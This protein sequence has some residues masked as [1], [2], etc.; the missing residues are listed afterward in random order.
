MISWQAVPAVKLAVVYG[1]GIAAAKFV[2]SDAVRPIL[3][4]ITLVAALLLVL[5]SSLERLR[6]LRGSGTLLLVIA[7]GLL[8][9]VL[10]QPAAEDFTDAAPYHLV[11]FTST[12]KPGLTT[13]SVEGIA[14]P[15]SIAGGVGEAGVPVRISLVQAAVPTGSG[16]GTLLLT[17]AE[18]KLAKRPLNPHTF[19]F[20]AYLAQRGIR[21][22]MYIKADE[23]SLIA[24][25]S[26]PGTLQSLRAWIAHRLSLAFP[27]PRESG[28]AKALV[29][30]DRSGLDQE[31]RE[32][33]TKTGA[34]HVLA[35]SG[36][37]TGVIASILIWLLARLPLREWPWLQVL[38]LAAGLYAYVALTGFSPS[39]QRSA[40][41]FG[42]LFAGRLLRLD[43]NAFNSLGASAILLLLFDPQL[44]W[45]LGFQLSYAAV[46]GILAFYPLF[47]RWF[48]STITP[49][50]KVGELLAVSLAATLATAPITAYHF[51]QF[52]VYFLLSGIVAVPLV[53]LAL[54]LALGG[55]AIDVVASLL[56]TSAYWAYAPAYL[57]VFLCNAVLDL[58]AD[59]PGALIEGL[60]P[61]ARAAGLAFAAVV[62][63]G[64]SIVAK[65]RL[66]FVV[67]LLLAVCLGVQVTVD[68]YRKLT[69]EELIV[70]GGRHAVLVDAIAD[71]RFQTVQED[72]N[73][74]VAAHRRYGVRMLADAEVFRRAL[75]VTDANAQSIAGAVEVDAAT[76]SGKTDGT[77]HTPLA[78]A[79][80]F[81]A[82][83]TI[84][85]SLGDSLSELASLG[86]PADFV[87][88]TNPRNANPEQLQAAFP[89]A[90]VITTDYVPQWKEAEWVGLADRLHIL[91]LDGAY[92]RPLALH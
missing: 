91:P 82:N 46:A 62:M 36:L 47:S 13:S 58:I 73:S 63:L 29:L 68:T 55:L 86:P 42:M 80:L 71:G 28:V 52:P 81:R 21:H 9:G 45:S 30:G 92:R 51:H 77:L 48:S 38:L 57:L 33:Y 74:D 53:M 67:S 56:D 85:I 64:A 41:M 87:V 89:N 60:Y 32:V 84:W 1:A 4:S 65:S 7:A 12:P 59:L 25:A 11:E 43:T 20:S 76:S 61:S 40:I 24:K 16:P 27:T 17:K 70:Y 50:R 78:P 22:Q 19:D 54:P 6:L 31:L 37:H 10:S 23:A 69:H 90:M 15:Y 49:V 39:V 35:V 3:V 83:N 14:H 88:V 18:P 2:G 26:E 34:V 44:L 79:R 72:L 8:A 75:A 5:P 66:S